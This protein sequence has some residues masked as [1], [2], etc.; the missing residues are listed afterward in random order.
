VI[1]IFI[2]DKTKICLVYRVDGYIYRSIDRERYAFIMTSF[3]D[4]IVTYLRKER[5]KS[6]KRKN[7]KKV[8]TS[9]G[10]RGT[11]KKI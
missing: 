4:D 2:T 10:F 7:R 8:K 6:Q 11:Q 3:V 5:E 9:N 1:N